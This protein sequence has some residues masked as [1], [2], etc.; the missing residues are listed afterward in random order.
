MNEKEIN[1]SEDKKINIALFCDAFY[2][3]IDGVVTVVN[4]Y[5]K[6]LKQKANVF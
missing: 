3:M 5:A 6:R 1:S 4:E 2:P